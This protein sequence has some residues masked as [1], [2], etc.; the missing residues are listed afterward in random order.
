M[1]K[2]YFVTVLLAVMAGFG[3]FVKAEPVDS[4]YE[5]G[6]E[7]YLAGR[8]K[9]AIPCFERD[10]EFVKGAEPV[11]YNVLGLV[12]HWLASC[13]YKLGDKAKAAEYEPSYY[14]LP[15]VDMNEYKTALYYDRMA[16]EASSPEMATMWTE[17]CLEEE[18]R[19]FGENHFMVYGSY[20]NLAT[21]ALKKGDEDMCRNYI[22]KAKSLHDKIA[23]TTTAWKASPYV[24]EGALDIAMDN[25]DGAKYPTQ[26]AW[27]LL[28]GNLRDFGFYYSECLSNYFT[29]LLQ[30][31]DFEAANGIAD[32]AQREYVTLDSVGMRENL[33]VGSSLIGYYIMTKQPTAGL[34]ICNLL[35]TALDKDSEGYGRLLCDRGRLLQL[36]GDA[37]GGANLIVESIEVLSRSHPKELE[38]CAYQWFYLADCYDSMRDFENS[39]KAYQTAL[40]G[41]KK[42]GDDGA[43]MYMSTLHRLGAI[44]SRSNEFEKAIGYLEECIKMMSDKGVGSRLDLAFIFKERGICEEGLKQYDKAAA[45]YRH[46]MK[47]FEENNLPF[48]HSLYFEICLK[49]LSLPSVSGAVSEVESA[50]MVSHL[51]SLSTPDNILRKRLRLQLIK[52]QVDSYMQQ[53]GFSDALE[54]VDEYIS[55]AEGLDGINLSEMYK[56]KCL[57]YIVLNRV[58]DARQLVQDYYGRTLARYGKYS[59]ESRS[60]LELYSCLIS[61]TGDIYQFDEIC[62]MGEEVIDVAKN[63]L[64]PGDPQLF[65]DII[66]AAGMMAYFKPEQAKRA[67]LEVLAQSNENFKKTE[68]GTMQSAFATLANIERSLGNYDLA[69]QYADRVVEYM[70]AIRNSVTKAGKY[71]VVGQ[72]YAAAGRLADAENAYK[73]AL[74]YTMQVNNG[75]NLNLLNVYNALVSL[76]NRMGQPALAAEYQ[77]KAMEF[78]LRVYKQNPMVE[79]TGLMNNIWFKYRSGLK[80]ECLEDIIRIGEIVEQF[81][82]SNVDKSI[83][84]KLLAKYYMYEG[85]LSVASASVDIA[86]SLSR[87]YDNL[88][89]AAQISFDD[90]RYNTAI[91]YAQ[92]AL[93]L[94]EQFFGKEASETITAHK[95]LADSYLQINMPEMSYLSYRNAFD[96]GRKY[97]SDNILTLTS[98]QR[99]DFW[100]ANFDFYR[101][102]LPSICRDHE[103]DTRMYGLLYDAMLFSNGLLLNADKSIAEVVQKSPQDV[104]GLYREWNSRK[105]LLQRIS[106]QSMTAASVDLSNDYDRQIERVQGELSDIER[107]LM[108]RLNE[109]AGTDWK[110]PLTTWKDVQKALPKGAAAIEYVDFPIDSVSNS[111]LAIVLTKGMKQPFVKEVYV[112]AQEE[113]FQSDE[114]YVSTE[115]GDMLIG[116]LGEVL[117]GCRD[118]YFSPQGPLCSLALEAMPLSGGILSD[119]VRLHRLSSTRE[120]VRK[121]GGKRTVG[122]ATLYGGLNYDTTVEEMKIDADKYPEMRHRGF[123]TENIFSLRTLREGTVEIPYLKGSRIEVDTI[124]SFLRRTDGQEP[125]SK[126]WNDGTETSFK[127]L[128][129]NYGRILHI[130]THGFFNDEAVVTPEVS[131]LAFTVED[132]ALEQSGLLMSGASNKYFGLTEMPYD[133]DDG[134]LKASEIAKLDLSGVDLAVLSACESGLGQVTGDGV[135]GLQRGF[136]KAG[137]GSILMS[138]WKVDDDATCCLM[139]EFYRHWLGDKSAGISPMTKQDALDAAKKVVRSNPSWDSPEFW[140]AFILLDAVE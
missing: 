104:V 66:N 107:K 124:M 138:L 73:K 72:T 140:A 90:G 22:A 17:K 85:E 78:S 45:D 2:R 130:S 29:I 97:I 89:L 103:V 57:L 137:V 118:I 93:E 51:Y 16:Q 111:G 131:K 14:E 55:L 46:A 116:S 61:Y 15:P 25:I 96:I 4:L 129:G 42:Q 53:G 87:D 80:T 127:A 28:R 63:V 132:Y 113:D 7:L 21:Q 108:K 83:P 82:W 125:V 133:L 43:G 13:H 60:A 9:E 128:S 71:S 11:D 41:F 38:H 135:F 105:E 94:A 76:Y 92:E 18:L 81:N 52:Y 65:S 110:L 23:V 12:S 70:D 98:A 19:L 136:K 95:I 48:G 86:L 37:Q 49:L 54:K 3:G 74:E 64:K 122:G 35:L 112:R 59:L 100:N 31:S 102:L 24:I 139:T 115:L 106:E 119:G 121:R 44:A 114:A 123:L 117:V 68:I 20:C 79:L 109:T 99:A 91:T 26:H 88:I 67:I 50:E 39:M 47:I 69:L 77:A 10:I 62:S 30:A 8:Y 126:T 134:I 56:D 34:E 33:S 75:D 101:T 27:E 1:M 6:R 58:D 5:A 36:A 32:V 120:L 84:S 40:K